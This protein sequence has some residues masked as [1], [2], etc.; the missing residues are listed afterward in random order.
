MRGLARESERAGRRFSSVHAENR[1]QG[2]SGRFPG[3][4]GTILMMCDHYI[5]GKRGRCTRGQGS[6]PP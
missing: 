1:Q 3:V 2:A 4:S 5:V 6:G